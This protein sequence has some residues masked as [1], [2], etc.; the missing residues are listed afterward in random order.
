MFECVRVV[1]TSG[2][3]AVW[4]CYS[5]TKRTESTMTTH[6]SRRALLGLG[7]VSIGGVGLAGCSRF[8]GNSAGGASSAGGALNFVWKGDA[9][10]AEQMRA[11]V[12]LFAKQHPDLDISTEYQ[13]GSEYLQKLAVRFAS[14]SPPD[15]MRMERESLREYADRGV[16]LDVNTHADLLNTDALPESLLN[17]GLVGGKLYGVAGGV[18]ST[19]IVID[20]AVF[21]QFGVEPPD[22]TAWSWEDYGRVC[23]QVSEASGG[24]V[25]GG[26]LPIGAL[27]TF[28]TWL[29]QQGLDLWTEDGQVG[30]TEQD[31]LP[32]Y[33]LWVEFEAMGAIPAGGAID[34]L[35]AAADQSAI[36][37]GLTASA[38]IPSNSFASFNTAAGGDLEMGYFPGES[39]AAARG[40]Q[41]IPALFWSISAASEVPGDAVALVDFLTN[42]VAAN[43]AMA[44]TNG[45][46]PNQDVVTE[47]AQDLSADEVRF[48]RMTPAEA[49]SAVVAAA[50]ES[51]GDV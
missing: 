2:E 7:A 50:Q 26:D 35:G 41:L 9:T 37:Q 5:N 47:L 19:S 24:A 15:V 39:T 49:A 31:V 29:R 6:L 25:Y 28:G 3:C 43:E 51:W 45:I 48:A 17:S 1:C 13:S 12:A 20:R 8:G 30:F 22:L 4:S 34:S 42:D 18:T 32:W 27:Q 44:G 11:A 40:M 16:L 10:R 46:P 38:M 33:E 36:A 23:A 14:S 21:T